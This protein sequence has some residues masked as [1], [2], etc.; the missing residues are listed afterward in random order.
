MTIDEIRSYI[1]SMIQNLEVLHNYGIV[2]RDIKPGNFL[3]SRKKKSGILIDYGLSEIVSIFTNF[4]IKL[5][6]GSWV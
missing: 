3:Y 1:H 2:H 6:I 4:L 5:Y